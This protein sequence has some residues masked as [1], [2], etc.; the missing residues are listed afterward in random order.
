MLFRVSDDKILRKV[1][2][3]P[4][5]RVFLTFLHAGKPNEYGNR[6]RTLRT[7][8]GKTGTA[9]KQTVSARVKKASKFGLVSTHRFVQL[10]EFSAQIS[11]GYE[12]NEGKFVFNKR[13][14][15]SSFQLSERKW[16]RRLKKQAVTI[17]TIEPKR[18]LP[19]SLS[20]L[21]SNY[22]ELFFGGNK[23][24]TI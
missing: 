7:I 20:D 21:Y 5:F 15:A 16:A 11:N 14:P 1:K 19:D 9:R 3:L 23:I 13:N 22:S 8:G 17:E 4:D 6:S 10:G 2:T 18:L 24:A 12:V